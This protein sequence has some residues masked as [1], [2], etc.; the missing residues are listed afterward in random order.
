[1]QSEG[2]LIQSVLYTEVSFIQSVLYTEVSFIFE[3][4]S[5]VPLLHQCIHMQYLSLLLV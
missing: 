1:M 5:E 2:S 4:L 3:P